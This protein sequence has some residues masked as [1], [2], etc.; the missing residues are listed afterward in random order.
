MDD[1]GRHRGRGR[2]ARAALAVSIVAL[3][4]GP[5][6]VAR[7]QGETVPIP[8]LGVW[9][10]QMLTYGEKH[11]AAMV[12]AKDSPSG[13]A[14]LG[15]TYYDAGRVYYQIADYTR[16]PKWNTY[17]DAAVSAYRRYVQSAKAE[18][19]GYG[20]VPGFWNFTTGLRMHA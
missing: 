11:G 10:K 2:G 18:G 4:L 14:R 17:A 20:A 15:P 3:L 13:D 7:S 16:D 12:V 9:E 6:S 1:A 8:Q 19:G 5:W